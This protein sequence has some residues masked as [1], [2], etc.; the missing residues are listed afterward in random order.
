MASWA[1]GG[2][3]A[4]RRSG[5]GVILGVGLLVTG[6]A[7]A[8]G[9]VSFDLE[10]TVS[11]LDGMVGDRRGVVVVGPGRTWLV[12]PQ[13]DRVLSTW[14]GGGDAVVVGPDGRIFTCGRS[15]VRQTELTAEGPQTRPLSDAPC[16]DIALLEPAGGLQRLVVAGETVQ[17]LSLSA[18][19]AP[20]VRQLEAELDGWPVLATQGKRLAIVTEG[21]STLLEEGPWGTSA[22]AT[23][24]K[25]GGLAMGPG[26][27]VWSLVDDDALMDVT[28]KRIPVADAPGRL[29]GGDLDGDGVQDL[30]ITHP[31]SG[32]LGLLPGGQT[33]ELQ[34]AV[35]VGVHRLALS[36]IDGDGCDEVMLATA[37]GRLTRLDRPCAA[38]TAEVVVPDPVEAAESAPPVEASPGIRRELALG[39]GAVERVRVV[40]GERLELELVDRAGGA[41]AFAASGG[42]SGLVVTSSG[43]LMYR[44][45]AED[46]GVWRIQVRLWEG[47]SWGRRAIFELEVV[48]DPTTGPIVP[49]SA[50]S[51]DL[52]VVLGEEVGKLHRELPVRS[53]LVGLGATIGASRGRSWVTLGEGFIPSGSPAVSVG[54]EG[55]ARPGLPLRWYAGIDAAP[56]FKYLHNGNEYRHGIAATGAVGYGGDQ[57]FVGGFFSAGATLIGLGPMARWMPLDGPNGRHSG[58]EARVMWMPAN[59]LVVEGMLLYTLQVGPAQPPLASTP[60]R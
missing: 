43:V 21:G 15:G 46:V 53:C 39:T 60:E 45:K 52:A 18:T 47:G 28:R 7:R 34:A 41:T 22:L 6:A 31:G 58:F 11:D 20:Q 59:D 4:V 23:G 48:R 3:V 5:A 49:S 2:W 9:P 55:G 44:S 13:L 24:G 40:A 17:I 50:D 54:C 33:E 35:P 51:G 14:E 19:G 42:P 38:R 27:W 57:T 56:F 10:A 25:T 8:A 37:A 16:K 36:D 26:S 32:I 12:A 1:R 29:M 30:V